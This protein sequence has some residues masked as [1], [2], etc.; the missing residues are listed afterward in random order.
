M[1]EDVE[2]DPSLSLPMKISSSYLHYFLLMVD[3]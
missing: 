2:D 3:I 1:M